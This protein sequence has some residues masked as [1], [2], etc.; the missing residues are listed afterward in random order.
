M[1]TP[2]P[3]VSGELGARGIDLILARIDATSSAFGTV[4]SHRFHP[5]GVLA[6]VRDAVG[7]GAHRETPISPAR[8]DE[9]GRYRDEASRPARIH[10]DRSWTHHGRNRNV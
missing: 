10:R 4:R 7:A 3:E 8:G 9:F 5:A 2:F 1:P 6:T